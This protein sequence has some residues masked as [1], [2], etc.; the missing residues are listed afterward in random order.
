VTTIGPTLTVAQRPTA[1]P[2]SIPVSPNGAHA[3]AFE[4]SG[5]SASVFS[6]EVRYVRVQ[7]EP[8]DS[9]NRPD[10]EGVPV[11]VHYALAHELKPE[12]KWRGLAGSTNR[13]LRHG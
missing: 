7:S 2:M 10:G 9:C 12:K 4:K 3:D 1:F 5:L 6:D 8:V 13:S 11:R